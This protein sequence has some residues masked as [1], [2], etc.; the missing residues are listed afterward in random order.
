MEIV[1]KP[2][3]LGNQYYVYDRNTNKILAVPKQDYEV[4]CSNQSSTE[5]NAVLKK[6]QSKGFFLENRLT[7]IK[8]PANDFVTQF[9]EALQD[10]WSS[11]GLYPSVRYFS[12]PVP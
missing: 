8:H 12:Y 4:L 11:K 5:K 7:E 6:Y 10:Y 3:K 1:L 9:E 2:F